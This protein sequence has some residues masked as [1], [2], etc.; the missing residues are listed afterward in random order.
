MEGWQV[1]L[2]GLLVPRLR[3]CQK[4]SVQTTQSSNAIA[5]R[6]PLQLPLPPGSVVHAHCILYVRIEES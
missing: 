4:P 3:S 6:I 2:A 5:G 1:D